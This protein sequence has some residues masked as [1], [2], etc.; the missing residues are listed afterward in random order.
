MKTIHEMKFLLNAGENNQL[1]MKAL[2]T[3]H[4]AM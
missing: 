1:Y 2:Q 4:D 3:C